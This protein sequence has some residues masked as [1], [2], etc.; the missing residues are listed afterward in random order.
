MGLFL[1]LSKFPLGIHRTVIP[2]NDYF[3]LAAVFCVRVVTKALYKVCAY[4]A[5]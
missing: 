1:N 3:E 4:S 2:F 5:V